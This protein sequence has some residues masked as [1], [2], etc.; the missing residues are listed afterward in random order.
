MNSE[1]SEIN[2]KLSKLKNSDLQIIC[3]NNN[4]TKNGNKTDLINRIINSINEN[5]ILKDINTISNKYNNVSL[6]NY[7]K[8]DLHKFNKSNLISSS[9]KLNI[10]YKNKNKSQ[11]IN[12][13]YSYYLNRYDK[14][15]Y[16]IQDY[17]RF[18]LYKKINKLKGPALYNRSL[19]NNTTDFNLSDINTIPNKYFFSYK[20]NDNFIYGFELNSIYKML[21]EYE[22]I[23]P[24]NRKPFSK[25]TINDINTLYKLIYIYNNNI[26]K[27][28]LSKKSINLRVTD[29]FQTMDKLGNYTNISW[30]FDLNR[31]KL[32]L[33]YRELED[34]WNYRL[35][36]TLEQKKQIIHPNGILF[37]IP[38]STIYNIS[39]KNQLQSICINIMN[40]LVTKGI[41]DD[42][43]KQGCYY[44]LMALTI[45]NP[46]TANALP[47]LANSVIN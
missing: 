14:Y 3:R 36:L 41:N 18:Y 46:D 5:I 47:W 13:F 38:L 22:C 40:K 9:I 32:R 23:N 33:F 39:C 29:I 35:S 27:I 24:Y 42:C 28:I 34:I 44:I 37:T 6:I 12:E 21:N 31:N 45:V 7:I 19:C 30:F 16:F 20:D 1:I 10:N 4:I 8:K 11:I 25:K 26:S 17:Y 43:K 15:I 2:I